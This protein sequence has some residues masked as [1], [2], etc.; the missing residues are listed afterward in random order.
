[1]LVCCCCFTLLEL[2]SVM[3]TIVR[4]GIKKGRIDEDNEREENLKRRRIVYDAV[5]KLKVKGKARGIHSFVA[6][7]LKMSQDDVRNMFK[8]EDKSRQGGSSSEDYL[9]MSSGA[10]TSKVVLIIF[11]FTLLKSLVKSRKNEGDFAT[12]QRT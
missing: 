7:Q 2:A 6:H 8:A 3:A 10:P 1:M 12:F 9:K 4:R 5:K 11:P